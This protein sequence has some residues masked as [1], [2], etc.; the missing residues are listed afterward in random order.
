MS[1]VIRGW[2]S[3]RVL[4]LDDDRSAIQI[5]PWSHEDDFLFYSDTFALKY[6]QQSHSNYHFSNL[7]LSN[8]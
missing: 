6:A 7:A 1:S 3:E 2:L 5:A 8:W 4:G